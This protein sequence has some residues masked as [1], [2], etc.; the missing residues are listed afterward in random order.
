MDSGAPQGRNRVDVALTTC[1]RGCVRERSLQL[2]SASQRRH[3]ARSAAVVAVAL[4]LQPERPGQGADAT[5]FVPPQRTAATVPVPG[6]PGFGA[7]SGAVCTIA[8]SGASP[9]R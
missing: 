9:K 7:Y 4:G 2:P 5:E 3:T 8:I 1:Q 6:C